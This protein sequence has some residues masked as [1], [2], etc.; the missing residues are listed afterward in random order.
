MKVLV[1][2]YKGFI[3][4]HAVQKLKQLNIPY[5]TYEWREQFP[6]LNDITHVM[7]FGAISSTT[8]TNVEKIMLQNYDS[9]ATLMQMCMNQN[10]IHFQYSSSASVYGLGN[11]FKE[12]APVDPRS[13]YAW[14]K[15]LIERFHNT[16]IN[17]FTNT[18]QG[19]RYFNVYGDRGEDHKGNQA[20]PY[21][22]FRKQLNDTGVI[23]I[24]ENS[25]NYIRDFI[26]VDQV[27]DIQ[28]K[29]L[30]IPES[31]IWNIGTGKP[32][33]FKTVAEAIGNTI[34]EIPMPDALKNSYQ[35][36]TCA[37]LTKLN[38]TL[39]KYYP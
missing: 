4:Q 32:K 12:S 17:E 29:F 15:Y 5:I 7:H 36:Y 25:E 31:G 3:G 19:F 24:F 10:N 11:D 6:S 13:P 22:T 30:S 14:S 37:D 26:H 1:T 2:G 33:S 23:K 21:H 8:E 20:S 18:I 39:N 35:R 27:L 34:I 38:N 28:F 9:T 16:H